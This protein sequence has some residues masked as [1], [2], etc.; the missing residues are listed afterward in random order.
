MSAGFTIYQ[1]NKLLSG[2]N[3]VVAAV[4]RDTVYDRVIAALHG[5]PLYVVYC[6]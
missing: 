3:L 2:L 1:L 6:M 5:K 4:L